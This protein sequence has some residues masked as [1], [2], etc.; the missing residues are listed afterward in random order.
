MSSKEQVIFDIKSEEFRYLHREKDRVKQ[1]VNI[2]VL[3]ER[4][5]RTKKINFYTNAKMILFSLF[6]IVLFILISVRF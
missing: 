1:K 2:D 4:L 6:T 5:N 3:N